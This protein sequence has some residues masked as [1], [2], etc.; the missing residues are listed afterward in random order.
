MGVQYIFVVETNK[1]CQSDWIYIKSS[2]EEFC[3]KLDSNIK[4]S[5]VYMDGKSKFQSKEAEINKL[6][7][8][9]SASKATNE[10]KVIFCF[11]LDNYDTEKEDETFVKNTR[12]YCKKKDYYYVWFCRDIEEVYLKRRLTNVEKKKEA[13]K[14]KAKK[15]ISTI[16]KKILLETK[17]KSGTSN[18]LSVL[19]EVWLYSA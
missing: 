19:R 3:I 12:D 14:F 16:D 17:F 9:Y 4:L 1:S 5:V 8:Q 18:L 11:D 13:H 6:K 15:S 7:K 2:I 10:S